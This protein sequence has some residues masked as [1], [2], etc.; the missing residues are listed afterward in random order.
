MMDK[1]QSTEIF[2][3]LSLSRVKSSNDFQRQKS[4]YSNQNFLN[5]SFKWFTESEEVHTL[6]LMKI[7]DE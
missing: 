6:M 7:S 3:L 1:V 5:G 2:V 4:F